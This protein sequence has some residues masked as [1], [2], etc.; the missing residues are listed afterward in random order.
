MLQ[1]HEMILFWGAQIELESW[2]AMRNAS[3][4]SLEIL[5]AILEKMKMELMLIDDDYVHRT[6]LK[7]FMLVIHK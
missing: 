1:L 4:P 6:E 5:Y 2:N 7:T 3:L